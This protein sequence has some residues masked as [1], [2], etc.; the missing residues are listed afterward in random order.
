MTSSLELLEEHRMFGGWQQRYRHV[1]E[2][3]NTAMTFSIYLPPTQDDTPPPVLYWLSGLTCNDENFTTKAGAQRVASELGLVLVMPD[4]SPRGDGV[5]DDAG[6]DLGQGAGF[7]V[8]ATQAPWAA[9]YRMYDYISSELP[10]LI[11]QHFNVNRRQSISGHSMGGHGALMLALRNP[12]QFQS[13]SA[14]APIVNP[15]QVPWGRKALTAYLGE[16]ETQW[17]QYDSCH[18]L[19]NSQKKLPMLVDQ[20]DCDQF[21]PDQLQPAKLEELASQYDWPL[22]LRTQSGYD[23]SYFFIASFIEDH[24]RF[25]ARYLLEE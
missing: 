18:L 19:A 9:H 23:H 25:H 20:G 2:T 3:L 5:A 22:T 6:Y 11:Q 7:Y 14:F 21:L 12:D 16:D 13:A 15:S 24:L 10:A 1:S 17:L 8:N 4:T